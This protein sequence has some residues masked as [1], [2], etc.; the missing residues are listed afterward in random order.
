MQLQETITASLLF[1][2]LFI[3]CMFRIYLEKY[4]NS[5]Y[6]FIPIWIFEFSRS[7]ILITTGDEELQPLPEI[8]TVVSSVN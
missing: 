2:Y 5:N 1:I 3:Y 4:H 7:T 8:N 6:L